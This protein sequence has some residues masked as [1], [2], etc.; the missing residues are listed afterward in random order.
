M[1]GT[2]FIRR[3]VRRWASF[4][5]RPALLGALRVLCLL[6]LLSVFFGAA[7]ARTATAR[8]SESLAG[9]GRELAALPGTALHTSPRL[10]TVN[11]VTLH[12]VAASSKLGVRE[13]LDGLEALCRPRAGIV[14]PPGI[15]G[16]L[17]APSDTTPVGGILRQESDTEGTIACLDP[18]ERLSLEQVVERLR[19]FA[20]TGNV[21]D[22]GDLRYAFVTKGSERTTLVV[23]W[24][25]GDVLVRD[26]FPPHTDAPGKDPMGIPRPDGARRVLSGIEH[27]A[28]YALTLYQGGRLSEAELL[29][30]YI[31]ELRNAGFQVMPDP[32]KRSLTAERD[33]RAVLIRTSRS[34]NGQTVASIAELS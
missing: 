29:D 11:G 33:G 7:L 23:L 28:P 21:A 13:L 20:D 26:M 3:D 1:P 6:A 34:R 32:S 24:T 4:A 14:V 19:R 16:D 30:W 15:P 5:P 12:V 27:G 9:F 8:V 10:L 25:E 2:S 22:V 31:S 17:R 18:R